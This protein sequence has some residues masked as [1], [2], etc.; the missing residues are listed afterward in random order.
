MNGVKKLLSLKK[1]LY[2]PL[3]V[4]IF[5]FMPSAHALVTG[6]DVFIT[7]ATSGVD[8]GANCANAHS[9]AWFNTATNWGVGAGKISAGDTVYLCGTITSRLNV[10]ASGSAGNIITITAAAGGATLDMQSTSNFVAFSFNAFQYITVDGLTGDA[11]SGNTTYPFRVINFAPGASDS[12]PSFSFYAN[13]GG[14]GHLAIRHV[15]I[16]GSGG[17]S[18]LTNQDGG[19][20]LQVATVGDVEFSYNWIHGVNVGT[21]LNG[22][23]VACWSATGTTSYTDGCNIH[24]NLIQY[25]QHDGIR[26]GS[27]ASLH[28]NDIT[29]VDGSGHSDSLLCQSG[30]YC[31]IYNNYVYNSGDQNIYIDNLNNSSSGHLRIYNNVINSNP[32]F[33]V[34]IDAEGGASSVWDDVVIANNTFYTQSASA[35]RVVSRGQVTNLAMLNNIFGTTSDISYRSVELPANTTITGASSWDY[36]IYS[37]ASANYPQVAVWGASQYRLVQ[38]QAL[39]PVRETHGVV[40]VPTYVNAGAADFHLASGDTI[41]KNNRP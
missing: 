9:V 25:L 31:A 37:T 12:T 18:S 35:I 13:T 29:G 17:S 15:E 28:D 7:Q 8:T 16:T 11:R 23:G 33:G 6:E 10:Q 36:N 21:K 5:G 3:L 40:G 14:E 4:L 22:T 1:F 32:G 24:H 20:Y 19:V 34:V 26:V 27:N 39:S 30:N 38:L 41:A 2:I